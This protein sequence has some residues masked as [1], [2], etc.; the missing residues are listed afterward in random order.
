MT[1]RISQAG[2]RPQAL[3]CRGFTLVEISVVIAIVAIA[4]SL[5]PVALPKIHD[6]IALRQSAGYLAAYLRKA[7]SQAMQSSHDVAVLIDT[8]SG[9][10][11]GVAGERAVLLPISAPIGLLVA[12]SER[13]S[14]TSGALRFF[15]DGSSTGGQ[16]E[17]G[18]HG[19]RKVVEIE[20][21]TGRVS[22]RD[23]DDPSNE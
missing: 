21:L 4:L 7:R 22:V 5:T 20:W 11:T 13:N 9:S 2:N 23:E 12:V 1:A 15:A 16:V 8:D 3:Q 6:G 18:P 19:N 17:F 10:V 14:G